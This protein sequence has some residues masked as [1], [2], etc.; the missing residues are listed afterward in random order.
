V[1]LQAVSGESGELGSTG[2]DVPVAKN[3]P[4]PRLGNEGE[5]YLNGRALAKQLGVAPRLLRRRLIS[6]GMEIV[7]VGPRSWRIR[8]DDFSRWKRLGATHALEEVESLERK[9]G[10]IRGAF[11]GAKYPPHLR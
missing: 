5:A 7:D 10:F 3:V 11:K 9:A 8:N 2:N 1:N 4:G 6:D